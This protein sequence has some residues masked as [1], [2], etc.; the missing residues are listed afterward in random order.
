MATVQKN[1]GPA[2]WPGSRGSPFMA[3]ASAGTPCTSSSAL[4]PRAAQRAVPMLGAVTAV[5]LVALATGRVREPPVL[6][7]GPCRPCERVACEPVA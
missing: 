7:N 6:R 5:P 4:P 2:R 1:G 3:R